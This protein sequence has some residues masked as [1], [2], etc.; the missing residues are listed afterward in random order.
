MK[1]TSIYIKNIMESNSSVIIQSE[2]CLWLSGIENVSGPARNGPRSLRRSHTRFSR[3]P[4]VL[5]MT[6]LSQLIFFFF[7]GGGGGGSGVSSPHSKLQIGKISYF[8]IL[9]KICVTCFLI[10]FA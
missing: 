9:R 1:G 4:S 10:C 6:K 8:P 3:E 2:I 7:L 5:P